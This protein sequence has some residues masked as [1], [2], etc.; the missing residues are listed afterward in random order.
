MSF[1]VIP[2]KLKKIRYDGNNHFLVLIP[3]KNRKHFAGGGLIYTCIK[4]LPGSSLECN[5]ISHTKI[6]FSNLK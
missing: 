2:G 3:D 1:D 4:C 5:Y 6:F